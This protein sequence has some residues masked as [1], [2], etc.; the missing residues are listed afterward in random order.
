MADITINEIT[1]AS[2]IGGN[3]YFD[4]F[5]QSTNTYL[6]DQYSKNRIKPSDYASVY[7]GAMQSALTEAVKL[8]IGRQLASAQ[9]DLAIANTSK[10]EIDKDLVS[11]EVLYKGAL[12]DNAIT[13][14]GL[15]LERITNLEKDTLIKVQEELIKKKDIILMQSR[16]DKTAKEIEK[17]IAD[18]A[19]VDQDTANALS[20][21]A[22]IVAE[23][24]RVIASTIK[25]EEDTKL[26]TKQIE[27]LSKDIKLIT[28]E[29]I[30]KSK[31]VQLMIAKISMM[32]QEELQVIANTALIAQKTALTAKEI[33]KLTQDILNIQATIRLTSAKVKNTDCETVKCSSETGLVNAR[34]TSE[35]ANTDGS[36][37]HK[38]SI[39][40]EN[41]SLTKQKTITETARTNGNVVEDNSVIGKEL[42]KLDLENKITKAKFDPEGI[43]LP[44][45]SIDCETRLTCAKVETERANYTPIGDGEGEIN[46]ESLLGTKAK[47]TLAQANT[48]EANLDPVNVKPDS[49][50]EAKIKKMEADANNA[51]ANY[52]PEEAGVAANSK[53]DCET[54]L[55]C[56]KAESERAN[57]TPIGLGD[58]E[59]SPTSLLGARADL[60]VN[61]S[62]T[63]KA[64]I[65]GED[66]TRDSL[67]FHKIAKM[68]SDANNALA[69]YNPI[70]AGVTE[71]SK[72]D[73]EAKLTCARVKSEAANYTEIGNE[74]DQI[75]PTS[76]LGARTALLINQAETELANTDG[77]KL[78]EN[79][80]MSA[81]IKKSEAD[82]KAVV[83]TYDP[84][85]AEVKVGSKID[86][87]ARLSCARVESERANFTAIGEDDGLIDPSSLL[88]A[89]AALLIHQGNTEEANIDP[90][91]V[92]D[93]SLY[94]AKIAKMEADANSALSAYDPVT[95]G[96]VDGSKIDCE[97][98]LSCARVESEKA[99]FTPIGLG[100]E[101]IN[102]T[103]LL[104]A[105]AD[106]LI[107]Q[108]AT[109]KA[110]IDGSD[111]KEDSVIKSKIDK[112]KYDANAALAN[113]NPTAAG[114]VEGSKIDCDAKLACAR[115]E[116]E[117]ANYTE[118]GNDPDQIDPTSYLGA[119]TELLI[120]QAKSELANIDGAGLEDNSFIKSKINKVNADIRTA[121]AQ[122]SP[123]EANVEEGS[124]IDCETKLSC[125]KK[126]TELAQLQSLGMNEGQLNPSSVMGSRA[127]LVNQ[128]AL[129]EQAN[130]DPTVIKPGSLIQSKLDKM[131]ADARISLAQI[132][133]V[134][135]EV[136]EGSQIDCDAKLTCVKVISESSNY[137]PIGINEGDLHPS[138]LIGARADLLIKQA[139]TEKANY[140]AESIE[141]D[142]L[143]RAKINKAKSD[144][145]EAQSKYDPI[146]AGVFSGS[147]ID[148]NTNLVKVRARGEEAQYTE[149]G[150]DPDQIDPTSLVGA[151]AQFLINQGK[152]EL[153]NTN[154]DGVQEGSLVAAQI[155]K[156]EADS[157]NSLANYNPE[158]AGV[159]EGSK[160]DC[161]AKLT[162]AKVATE[163]AQL[164]QVGIGEGQLSPTSIL[165]SAAVLRGFQSDTEKANTDAT[166]LGAD[167]FM[168]A[169]IDKMIADAEVAH[170]P[171]EAVG[172]GT[173]QLNPDSKLGLETALTKAQ[174]DT[175]IANTDQS[176]ID[177]ESLVGARIQFLLAQKAKLDKEILLTDEEI[178]KIQA[179][180]GFTLSKY[181]EAPLSGS[182]ID[183]QAKLY[184]AQAGEHS[185]KY[186]QGIDPTTGDAVTLSE[187]TPIG[188]EMKLTQA[189]AEDLIIRSVND[190]VRANATTVSAAADTTRA[191]N[192]S[193]RAGNDSVR[194][195]NDT[196]VSGARA[197]LITNQ[198]NVEVKRESVMEVQKGLYVKQGNHYDKDTAIR[199]VKL[200]VDMFSISASVAK[201]PTDLGLV[202]SNTVIPIINTI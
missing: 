159:V 155:D 7:L 94:K 132:D 49:V 38:G 59:I 179:E 13:E 171:L 137:T 195:G 112:M 39:I 196:L 15:I 3:G 162:C 183:C 56:A 72:I 64:N 25:I 186:T 110:N 65:N 164:I 145:I 29:I 26:T 100:E 87:E 176:D 78:K 86:C 156:M 45:S 153:A 122:Y 80:F 126:D 173:G 27:K 167:S 79:S 54:K 50:Y 91:K 143:I 119:R 12:T 21:N 5:M 200:Y 83:A 98:K 33:T 89:R 23:A 6:Q 147:L 194:A 18:I 136:Q 133:P 142:S 36:V 37:I 81:K 166:D 76:Y 177:S 175:E 199:K 102:P 121:V 10:I 31:E 141:E 191:T 150:N 131:K 198:A 197:L 68:E 105:R 124:K 202:P 32:V 93:K 41:I 28:Q 135:A 192:D 117:K 62:S 46:P 148:E 95:A 187:D 151:R 75:D 66:V 201:D 129:T 109:E 52:N 134:N 1:E 182:L 70:L 113:Y 170:A 4:R 178:A 152:T 174:T 116:S 82:A 73:C 106:L 35:I 120:N 90:N 188:A 60:L 85:L 84:V 154:A 104:G 63:E 115:A 158:E 160:M 71:G 42:E 24:A 165:G 51:L 169:K 88:G 161:E 30:V 40:A 127:N 43:V 114:V 139:L 101:E 193:I 67:L 144:A 19:R 103:S 180:A 125:A 47:L 20:Q 11:A 189:R 97:A 185:I 17:L 190:T 34:T 61:Q 149:I 140:N 172:T 163:K 69:N 44:G 146:G 118:I 181:K 16:I 157:K 74:P 111:V 14:N 168:K 123:T 128:Q 53:I 130:I 184:C 48:E 55:A 58:K 2:T 57:Y 77:D 138:S 9:A 107:Q 22:V 8:A 99:N 108:K 92:K 96:V